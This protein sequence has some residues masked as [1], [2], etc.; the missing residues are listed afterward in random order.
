MR[1]RISTIPLLVALALAATAARA[2]AGRYHVYSCRTPSGQSAPTDGW[3]GS[4]TGSYTFVINSCQ[5]GGALIGALGD[6]QRNANSSIA[7]WAFSSPAN[8]SIVEGTLWRAGDA[9]GGTVIGA[10]YEFW[11]AGPANQNDPA[12]AFGPCSSGSP[13]SSGTGSLVQPMSIENRLAVP[14]PNLGSHLYMDA[15]CVGESEYNC[16]EG[17]HDPNGY[18]AAIYLFAADLVLEQN[19]GPSAGGVS[20]E[21]AS[22]PVVG[23]TSDVAFSASDPGAGVYEA[24]FFVDGQLVQGTVLDENGGRCRDAGQT[25]DGLAAFLYVE[26]C[27]GSVSADVGFD[28]TRASDGPHHLLVRVI[29]AAGN[30]APVLDRTITVANRPAS[31]GPVAPG[32][33]NGTVASSQATLTVSWKGRRSERLTSPYGRAQ[34]V[35]GRLS[36]PGGVPIAGAQIDLS[37]TPAYTGAKRAP[38]LSPITGSDGSFT[39]HIPGGVSSR[40][41][42]F[43]YRSHLG[44]PL[45]VATR[46]LTLNVGAGIV[47]SVNPRTASVGRSIAFRGRLLGGSIPRGGKPVVLEAR[48]PGSTWIEFRVVRSDARGRFR[49]RYRFKFPGPVVYQFRVL[50]EPE[51]DYPFAA[52]ASNVVRVRER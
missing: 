18:A 27:L 10:R 20:G 38:M 47:L 29:D 1:T 8:T 30:A 25:S 11:F 2:Q 37:A 32:P 44:D 45:P 41:L 39:V 7:T 52:G 21:L 50:S 34:T 6:A 51:S 43:A 49:A 22:A 23:G 12:N 48:S 35:V 33:P 5:S 46:T 16:K 31:G 15:S 36:G 14:I 24:Q 13:C 40:S 19:A 28:T 42:L 9:E 26:P 3:S 17:E 4:R